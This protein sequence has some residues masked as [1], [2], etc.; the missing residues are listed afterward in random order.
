MIQKENFQP[1]LKNVGVDL[2]RAGGGPPPELSSNFFK[3][4]LSI[5]FQIML[6]KL[7]IWGT[8]RPDLFLKSRPPLNNPEKVPI[9]YLL[10]LK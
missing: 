2:R 3:I 1:N 5:F 8:D 9:Y 7:E 10:Q 6:S 4:F